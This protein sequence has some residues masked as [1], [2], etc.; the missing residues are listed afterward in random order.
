M[1]VAGI[2]I[3]GDVAQHADLRHFFFDGA[4]GAADEVIWVKRFRTGLVASGWIGIGKQGQA[5]DRKL[6]GVFGGA[7]GFVDR[8]ARHV[9]HRVDWHAKVRPFDHEQ[10]PDQVIGG[11]DV[12]AHHPARPFAA[13]IAARADRKLEPLG[14]GLGR[15]RSKSAPFERTA[16][17]DR[18]NRAPGDFRGPWA[19]FYPVRAQS[20]TVGNARLFPAARR[21]ISPND[22][23]SCV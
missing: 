21:F 13:P 12:F 23:A 14:L 20:A 16:E 15:R 1:A 8:K 7:D 11:D 6:G 9:R 5:W 3:E 2:G 17:F 4:N 10:R 19:R 22:C 18:H